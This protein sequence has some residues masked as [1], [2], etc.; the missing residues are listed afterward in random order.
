ME[1]KEYKFSYV[2]GGV[3]LSTTIVANNMEEAH[4]KGKNKALELFSTAHGFL[5]EEMGDYNVR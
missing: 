3:R 5:T 4:E 2:V 1:N